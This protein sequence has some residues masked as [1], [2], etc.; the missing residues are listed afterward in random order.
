MLTKA[1][2]DKPL[3]LVAQLDR[4]S[5]YGTEGCRFESCQVHSGKRGRKRPIESNNNRDKDLGHNPGKPGLWSFV[6]REAAKGR[7]SPRVS[8]RQKKTD[9]DVSPYLACWEWESGR[10]C[11]TCVALAGSAR[12]L[13]AELVQT[14][15]LHGAF[16][17]A[18][19]DVSRTI[20][21]PSTSWPK[22]D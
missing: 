16:D 2:A 5:V 6:H 15:L 19:D 13:L 20:P 7:E 17:L 4:A 11:C 3:A 14:D 1:V 9:G 8:A 18:G 10:P 22:A 21:S 12:R